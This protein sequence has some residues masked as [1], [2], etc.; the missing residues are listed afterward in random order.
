MKT[1]KMDKDG[2]FYWN[3]NKAIFML[4]LQREDYMQKMKDFHAVQK[5]T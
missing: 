3:L 2:I 4:D 5:Q 1:Y